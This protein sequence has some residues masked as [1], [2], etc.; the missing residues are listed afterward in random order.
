M[1]AVASKPDSRS[2]FSGTP[3]DADFLLSRADGN[4]PF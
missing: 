1:R 3:V 2:D 4:F